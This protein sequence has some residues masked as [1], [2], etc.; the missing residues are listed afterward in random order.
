MTMLSEMIADTEQPPELNVRVVKQGKIGI[1]EQLNSQHQASKKG[2]KP[3]KKRKK[4]K[5]HN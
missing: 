4:V 3:G 5:K 2:G 1:C